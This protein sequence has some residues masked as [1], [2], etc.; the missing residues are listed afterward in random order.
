MSRKPRARQGNNSNRKGRKRKLD[1]MLTEQES[2][3]QPI[4]DKASKLEASTSKSRAEMAVPLEPVAMGKHYI[5]NKKKEE[6]R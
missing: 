3:P 6:N 1:P 2:Q 5:R 4:G